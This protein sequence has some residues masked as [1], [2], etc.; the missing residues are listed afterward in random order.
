MSEFIERFE[1]YPLHD[2]LEQLWPLLEEAGGRKDLDDS[3]KEKLA[4]L[5]RVLTFLKTTLESVNPLLAQPELMN[6]LG[7]QVAAIINELNS[8]KSNNNLNHIGTAV[9]HADKIMVIS[10]SLPIVKTYKDMGDISEALISLRRSSSQHIRRL[11]EES[12]KLSNDI[13]SI[14]STASEKAARLDSQVTDIDNSLKELYSTF[15]ELK[16]ALST[17]RERS[18]VEEKQ[19][20]DSVRIEV[21][22]EAK[23]LINNYEGKF[24]L[25]RNFLSEQAKSIVTELTDELKRGRELLE[26]IGDTAITGRYSRAA[27]DHKASANKFRMLAMVFFVLMVISGLAT[28]WFAIKEANWQ[29]TLLRMFTTFVF[30]VPALYAARESDHHRK[31][32]DYDHRVHLELS[33]LDPFLGDLEPD[34]KKKIKISLVQKY[35]GNNAPQMV[36]EGRSISYSHIE[37][38]VS[39]LK[40]VMPK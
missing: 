10:V 4:H 8:L 34:E 15:G 25:E 29:M 35:F 27:S 12:A 5:E 19:G 7:N 13:S 38:I 40:S 18:L 31:A 23:E 37:K 1:N 26:L 30:L 36:S 9:T 6:G 16:G 33:A 24:E 14:I 21:R 17:E 28:V 11:E 22:E 32:E 20:H 3:W 39:I 2:Q